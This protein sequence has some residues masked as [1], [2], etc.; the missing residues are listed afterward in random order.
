MSEQ[1]QNYYEME[2]HLM[3]LDVWMPRGVN[4]PNLTSA[5]ERAFEPYGVK[6]W[7]VDDWRPS[8]WLKAKLEKEP[9]QMEFV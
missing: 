7:I 1:S 3:D 6:G 8:P 9:E 5:L 2:V 4:A